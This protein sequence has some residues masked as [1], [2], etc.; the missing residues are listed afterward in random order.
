MKWCVLFPWIVTL[1]WAQWSLYSAR[2]LT[3]DLR[4][5]TVGDVLTILVLE[6]A[7]A[8]NAAQTGEDRRSDLRIGVQGNYNRF[9]F[10]VGGGFQSGALFRGRGETSRSERIRA[11][12][13]AQVIAVDTLGNLVVE[14]QRTTRINGE[15]QLIRIR[16]K[17]RP[18]DILPDNTVPSYALSELVLIY[19]GDGTVSRAQEP[20]L[21]T[22]LLRLLF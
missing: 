6:D 20:G 3:S 11:R 8:S 2:S 12:L 19:E 17:V 21:I 15:E 9:G 4:A 13:T 18:L 22:R 16:G 1:G 7:Q 14:G 5:A 10:Q